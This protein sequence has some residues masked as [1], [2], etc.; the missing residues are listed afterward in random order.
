MGAWS[1]WNMG[2]WNGEVDDPHANMQ[3]WAEDKADMEAYA[4]F[5][6][7]YHAYATDISCFMGRVQFP[8]EL[9]ML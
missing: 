5:N 8:G 1:P 3:Y 6:A 2:N 9:F 4:T 7:R